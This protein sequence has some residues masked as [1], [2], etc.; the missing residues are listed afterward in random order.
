MSSMEGEVD[1]TLS[2]FIGSANAWIRANQCNICTTVSFLERNSSSLGD[3]IDLHQSQRCSYRSS[4][5]GGNVEDKEA[6]TAIKLYPPCP[7]WFL[8]QCPGWFFSMVLLH[9]LLKHGKTVNVQFLSVF[10]Y[11]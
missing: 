1:M 6:T 2:Y 9:T 7:F 5:P 8:R 4:T 10:Y 11:M 3:Y